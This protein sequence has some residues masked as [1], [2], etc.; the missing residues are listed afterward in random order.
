MECSAEFTA[1][2]TA[3]ES[4]V[5]TAEVGAVVGA[6]VGA[7][8][9]MA[10]AADRTGVTAPEELLVVAAA[11]AAVRRGNGEADDV[12]DDEDEE[13]EALRRGAG[14]RTGAGD[15]D[16]DDDDCAVVTPRDLAAAADLATASSDELESEL[17]VA[18]LLRPR[19]V[20]C[21]VELP[22]DDV[23]DRPA[24]RFAVGLGA[25]L[26]AGFTGAVV[27]LSDEEVDE[28]AVG[29]A[30]GLRAAA[31]LSPSDDEDGD[32]AARAG[33]ALGT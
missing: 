11:A 25:G 18:G 14:T 28:R 13:I 30:A 5:T 20:G 26:A 24:P 23:E 27:S 22:D 29:F 19:I 8:T 3:G 6:V 2:S 12:D 31:V 4:A 1:A 21:G 17:Y 33:A 9:G 32:A 10:A 7:G 15:G 16:D